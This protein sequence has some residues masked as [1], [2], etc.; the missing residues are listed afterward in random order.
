MEVLEWLKVGGPV[1]AIAA[2]ALVLGFKLGMKLL[3][4]FQETLTAHTEAMKDLTV[5][6][7]NAIKLFERHESG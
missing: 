4:G 5:E 2:L 3:N 7:K 1:F 6:M